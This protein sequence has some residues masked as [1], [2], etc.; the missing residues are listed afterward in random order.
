M[1]RWYGWFTHSVLHN[2]NIWVIFEQGEECIWC[3]LIIKDS[4]KWVSILHQYQT[5]LSLVYL[6][7]AF[8]SFFQIFVSFSFVILLCSA[9]CAFKPSFSNECSWLISFFPSWNRSKWQTSEIYT[10][11]FFFG[12]STK[13]SP[14]HFSPLKWVAVSPDYPKYSVLSLWVD[15][16]R[17]SQFR[18]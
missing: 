4:T 9:T 1:Q 2:L 14:S 10:S 15:E 18:C 13:S 6:S 3:G 17:L 7:V 5:Y 16:L 8:I 11:H 12:Q